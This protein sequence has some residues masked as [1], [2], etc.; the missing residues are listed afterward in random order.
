MNMA[1]EN[2]PEYVLNYITTEELI[3][4]KECE[5]KNLDVERVENEERLEYLLDMVKKAIEV[6]KEIKYLDRQI[7]ETDNYL[8][9]LSI[10]LQEGTEELTKLQNDL[11]KYRQEAEEAGWEYKYIGEGLRTSSKW[12]KKDK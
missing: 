1:E 6:G 9:D 3:S 5:L 2:Y 11:D 4:E 7:D 10:K 8:L 12:A